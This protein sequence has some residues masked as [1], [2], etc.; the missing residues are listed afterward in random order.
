M[1]LGFAKDI[2]GLKLN[3]LA[4]GLG[5]ELLECGVAVL[6]LISVLPLIYRIY[7]YI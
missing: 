3:L 1:M 4:L 6:D 7:I 2:G 5:A